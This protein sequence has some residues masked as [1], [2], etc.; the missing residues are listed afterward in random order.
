MIE[1]ARANA[2]ATGYTNVEFL[3][4]GIDRLPLDDASAD[5]VIATAFSISRPTSPPSSAKSSACSSPAAASPSATSPSKPSCRS[6]SRRA[7]LPMLAVSPARS[8]STTTAPS[9]AMPVSNCRDRRQRRRYQRLRQSRRPGRLLL[10]GNGWGRRPILLLTRHLADPAS[11]SDRT[12][13]QLRR[14]LR[15]RQRQGVCAETSDEGLL[16]S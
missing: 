6:R 9:C 3:L 8:A 11:G 12:A 14:Q 4:A 16:R 5:C 13:L 1:R 15:S 7:S 2:A 10:A